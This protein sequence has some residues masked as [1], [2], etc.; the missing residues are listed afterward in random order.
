MADKHST[1]ELHTLFSSFLNEKMCI[2]RTR[3]VASG[4]EGKSSF[5]I[6][7]QLGE[8]GSDWNPSNR[9]LLKTHR[10]AS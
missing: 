1:T 8:L 10:L 2:C 7:S 5:P 4:W 6:S 9:L 3:I